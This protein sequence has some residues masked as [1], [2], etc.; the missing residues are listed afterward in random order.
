[1]LEAQRMGGNPKLLR[2]LDVT[3]LDRAELTLTAHLSTIDRKAERRAALLD[4]GALVAFYILAVFGAMIAWLVL[5]G[6]V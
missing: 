2:R 1:M 5:A 6:H 4:W 3:A